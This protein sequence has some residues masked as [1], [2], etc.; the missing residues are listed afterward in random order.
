MGNKDRVEGNASYRV[1]ADLDTIAQAM[2]MAENRMH[3]AAS[4]YGGRAVEPEVHTF[5][6]GQVVLIRYTAKLVMEHA[7]LGTAERGDRRE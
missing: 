6:A 4:I 2:T 3:V 1:D 7:P 5:Q